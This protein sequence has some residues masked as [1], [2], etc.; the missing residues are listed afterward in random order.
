MRLVAD[1]LVILEDHKGF[2]VSP[3]SRAEMIDLTN[4][5][6]DLESLAI[7]M[8]I[9]K[10]DDHWEANL[11]G[12]FHELSKRPQFLPDGLPNPEWEVRHEAFHRT[13]HAGC[14]S[15]WLMFFCGVLYERSRRYRVLSAQIRVQ[16]SDRDVLG[17]HEA[18]LQAVLARDATTAVS[19]MRDHL[20]R[21]TNNLLD[22]YP[23]IE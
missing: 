2:R 5:R 8:A 14:G 10:G 22:Y 23:E 16:K 1:G 9:E 7:G 21:T 20:G 13:I 6:C 12:R 4:I 11:L 18:I 19:L 3:V 17:E 15:S